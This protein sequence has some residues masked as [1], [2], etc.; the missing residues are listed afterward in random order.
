[1]YRSKIHCQHILK[2]WIFSN[3]PTHCNSGNNTSKEVCITSY[4]TSICASWCCTLS[5][6][7][8][9]LRDTG[10]NQQRTVVHWTN[11][12]G[13]KHSHSNRLWVIQSNNV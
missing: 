7:R 1:M 10:N 5:R 3:V 6:E 2:F 4:H 11:I 8:C 9:D 13:W 12:G